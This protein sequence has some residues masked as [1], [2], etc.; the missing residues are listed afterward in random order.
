MMSTPNLEDLQLSEGRSSPVL[1]P[2]LSE[3]NDFKLDDDDLGLGLSDDM[4]SG[5]EK[6]LKLGSDHIG[7]SD[8][9]LEI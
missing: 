5:E 7:L 8:S 9:D 4:G 3:D 1:T 6:P 2:D